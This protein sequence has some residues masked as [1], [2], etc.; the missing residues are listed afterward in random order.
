MDK[1]Q[2][3]NLQKYFQSHKV[4]R[5][6]AHF[7]AMQVVAIY[8]LVPFFLVWSERG[9]EFIAATG[10]ALVVSW[11]VLVQLIAFLHPTARPYQKYGFV[12]AGGDGLFSGLDTRLDSFP[13][14]HVTALIALTLMIILF[15]SPLAWL[16]FFITVL[17]AT[18]RVLLGYHYL[19]DV[20][21]GLLLAILVVYL[22]HIFGV[23]GFIFALVS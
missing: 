4:L 8:V 11:G 17:V 9:R 12:P 22:L 13:S 14:G 1:D 6:L 20:L 15:N 10:L 5:R 3:L 19:R 23:F 7:F 2:Y 16:S 18:A 21:G